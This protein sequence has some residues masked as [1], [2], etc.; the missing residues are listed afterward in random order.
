MSA[1][2]RFP[3]DDL[4]AAAFY[5][6]ADQKTSAII[7]EAMPLNAKLAYG[8]KRAAAT[9]PTVITLTQNGAKRGRPF[10][11]KTGQG[12][13]PAEL[14]RMQRARAKFVAELKASGKVVATTVTRLGR[15]ARPTRT[16]VEEKL[17]R[18]SINTLRWRAK[19][20][21]VAAFNGLVLLKRMP[22]LWRECPIN[23]FHTNV[24][25]HESEKGS[26]GDEMASAEANDLARR[27]AKA[28]PDIRCNWASLQSKTH[29]LPQI[30]RATG[31]TEDQALR[32]VRFTAKQPSQGRIWT[33]WW[34]RRA[35]ERQIEFDKQGVKIRRGL[36]REQGRERLGQR[37]ATAH[38]SGSAIR[39]YAKWFR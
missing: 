29:E 8:S 2:L 20:G 39:R 32:A 34:F 35:I 38:K 7:L 30:L 26:S 11:V 10:G 16:L 5:C 27:M 24:R 17:Y 9:P 21:D 33:W 13:S 31:A 12:K 15:P 28:H 18:A 3:R 36:D 19:R 37:P 23:S 1:A 22:K 25:T 14:K 6:V 4:L